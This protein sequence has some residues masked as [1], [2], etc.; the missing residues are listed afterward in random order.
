MLLLVLLL[1][2][3]LLLERVSEVG[4]LVRRLSPT[5]FLHVM[6]F[7]LLPSAVLVLLL[8]VLLLVLLL[9]VLL[10]LLTP[11]QCAR[12]ARRCPPRR[13]ATPAPTAHR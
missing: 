5:T 9:L 1:L 13:L 10:L 8:L 2:V 4:G 3:L 12:S 7:P 11:L 6:S